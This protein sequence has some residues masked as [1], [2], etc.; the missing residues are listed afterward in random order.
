MKVLSEFE[1]Y[2]EGVKITEK[3]IY[4][5]ISEFQHYVSPPLTKKEIEEMN[6]QLYN[7]LYSA[8]NRIIMVNKLQDIT[9]STGKYFRVTYFVGK[10][11]E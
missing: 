7:H 9:E 11:N 2:I 6:H 5:I 10:E 8:E 4:N 1:G 3:S